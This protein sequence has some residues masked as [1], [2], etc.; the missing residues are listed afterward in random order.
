M[1]K[2]N[3]CAFILLIAA[4][5][6]FAAPDTYENEIHGWQAKRLK[7]LQADEGWP[8]LAGLFWLKEGENKVGSDDSLPVVLPASAPKVA[9]TLVMSGGKVQFKPEPSVALTLDEKPVTETIELTS[10][11]DPNVDPTKLRY[12]PVSF[13][14]IKRGERTGVR[15]RDKNSPVRKQLTSLQYYPIDPSWRFEAT[16][17]PYNPPRKIPVANILGMV[18]DTDFVGALVF[19]K[20]GTRYRLDVQEEIDKGEKQLFVIF[21][22]KTNRKETYGSGRYI[23]TSAPDNNGTVILD[24]NKA[25]SPPCAFTNYATCPLPPRQNKLPIQITA[26][27]KRPPHPKS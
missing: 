23:Y 9:G 16:F 7:N 15:V 20:N 3:F 6:S 4:C 10:D 8:T 13:F 25:Y 27:E 26:G 11:E 12:G 5:C 21:G 22:D 19:K 18:E 24:F 2:R 1:C 17:E 14:I